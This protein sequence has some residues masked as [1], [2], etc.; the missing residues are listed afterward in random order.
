MFFLFKL[1]SWLSSFISC[2]LMN[3]VDLPPEVSWFYCIQLSM[4]D[5]ALIA[6]HYA[7]V[8]VLTRRRGSRSGNS[9]TPTSSDRKVYCQAEPQ[10]TASWILIVNNDCSSIL[11]QSSEHW[12]CISIELLPAIFAVIL[13]SLSYS[14]DD[15]SGRGGSHLFTVIPFFSII[16]ACLLDM[17]GHSL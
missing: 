12:D 9:A 17:T 14:A 15:K 4:S 7:P 2:L 13:H 11:S 10:V 1:F 8:K 5:F 3:T 16:C 6:H